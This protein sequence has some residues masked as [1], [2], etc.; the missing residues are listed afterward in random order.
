M[1]GCETELPFDFYQVRPL[2]VQFS[3]LDLSSD[4]GLLLVPQAEERLGI[5][6]GLAGCIAEWRDPEKVIHPLVDLVSW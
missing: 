2:S 4:A 3:H 5:C 1:T 6:R